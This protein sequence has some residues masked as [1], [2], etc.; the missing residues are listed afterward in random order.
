MNLRNVV[1]HLITEKFAKYT[2]M[3]KTQRTYIRFKGIL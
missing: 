3:K 2:R 1:S